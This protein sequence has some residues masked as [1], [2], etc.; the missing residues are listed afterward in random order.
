[1]ITPSSVTADLMSP[2]GQASARARLAGVGH[3]L[4]EAGIETVH[5]G[6]PRT[7]EVDAVYVGWHPDCGMKDIEA[8]C[9]A[10][11]AGAKLYVASDVPFFATRQGRAMGYSYAIAGAIRRVTK[12][13]AIL[14]GKPSLHALRLPAEACCSGW[15]DRRRRRRPAGRGHDGTPRRRHRLRRHDRRHDARCMGAPARGATPSSG[16]VAD[17]RTC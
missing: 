14:T 3:S 12:A 6:E 15:S 7:S 10:I 4:R 2:R 16:V 8:A 11:W 1:M 9:H 13:R 5:T 17:L